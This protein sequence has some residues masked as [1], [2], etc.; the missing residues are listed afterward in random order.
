MNPDISR[1]DL[2]GLIEASAVPIP[3]TA[4]RCHHSEA[5]DF[6]RWGRQG[7]LA[8]LMLYGR[9]WFSL[10]GRRRWGRVGAEALARHRA[11]RLGAK[12]GAA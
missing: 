5:G 7:G 10:L 1:D 12:T 11:E 8:T 9:P 3:A 2:A 4:H 6:S